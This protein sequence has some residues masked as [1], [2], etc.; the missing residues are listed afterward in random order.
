ME[1]INST[2]HGLN[3]EPTRPQA[4]HHQPVTSSVHSPQSPKPKS[5]NQTSLTDL[6]HPPVPKSTIEII[7]IISKL[8]QPVLPAM[9]IFRSQQSPSHSFITKE[10][11]PKPRHSILEPVLAADLPQAQ[12]TQVAATIRNPPHLLLPRRCSL[13]AS[14]P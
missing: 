14:P 9:N 1:P 5:S 13:L 7:S 10:T 6:H 11:E 8:S 2:I 4:F 3:Q 12:T